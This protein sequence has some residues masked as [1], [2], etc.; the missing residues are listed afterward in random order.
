VKLWEPEFPKAQPLSL[1]LAPDFTNLDQAEIEV[2][3]EAL[4]RI[5][6]EVEVL[7]QAE[8]WA[9]VVAGAEVSDKV[10]AGGKKGK[11]I[12]YSLI[13]RR[14]MEVRLDENYGCL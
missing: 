8:V 6:V 13:V 12:V 3:E 5:W 4:A 9:A 1:A 11:R 14:S 10:S 7:G 2:W